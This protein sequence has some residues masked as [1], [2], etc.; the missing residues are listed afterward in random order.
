[1]VL[2]R[3]NGFSLNTQLVS[4]SQSGR[5]YH[6]LQNQHTIS[7]FYNIKQQRLQRYQRQFLQKRSCKLLIKY[8]IKKVWQNLPSDAAFACKNECSSQYKKQNQCCTSLQLIVKFFCSQYCL[9][10]KRKKSFTVY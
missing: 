5:N 6:Q 1:M 9:I 10:T 8:I 4:I 2:L 7:N 3:R